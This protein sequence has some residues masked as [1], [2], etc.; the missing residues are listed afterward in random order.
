M[1]AA[2]R[3]QWDDG[4]N[5]L[6]VAPGVVFGYDRNVTTNT[7]LRRARHRGRQRR[8]QRARPRPRRASLHDLPD[9]ARRRLTRSAQEETRMPVNLHH[10]NFL[11]ELDFTGDELRYLIGLGGRAQGGQGGRR[12]TGRA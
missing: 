12:R 8:R 4:T 5:F 2:E 11:K 6:A 1:R 10:R 7:M 3:E 9:P